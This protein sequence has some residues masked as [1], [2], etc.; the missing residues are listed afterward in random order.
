MVQ[1]EKVRVVTLHFLRLHQS[2]FTFSLLYS[3]AS[4]DLDLYKRLEKFAKIH[5]KLSTVGA[6]VL[7]RQTWYLSEELV[8][9]SLFD[10][11]LPDVVTDV[12]SIAQKIS[13]LP[14]GDLP[15]EKPTLPRIGKNVSDHRFCWSSFNS[16]H[17][18]TLLLARRLLR[19][20]V[21]FYISPLLDISKY[22]F[23]IFF[24]TTLEIRQILALLSLV[25]YKY[26]LITVSM[27]E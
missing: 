20:P 26:N 21:I 18:G 12:D 16:M 9:I 14:D 11:N 3:A 6:K 4:S 5:K 27:P 25:Y 15:I 24:P 23:L 10:P 7:Q 1:K 19:T 17:R 8:P 22:E 13:R 2:W